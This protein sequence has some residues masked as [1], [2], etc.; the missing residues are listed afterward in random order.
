M[1]GLGR[2]TQDINPRPLPS[3]HFYLVMG[4]FNARVGTRH[5]LRPVDGA[6]VGSVVGPYNFPDTNSNGD[7]LID[8]AKSC[9]LRI[10]NTF[11]KHSEKN[12]R[13][14][15]HGRGTWQVLDHVLCRSWCL[16]NMVDSRTRPSWSGYVD[17]DH[18]V[19]T[20]TVRSNPRSK[21][22]HTMK[23]AQAKNAEVQVVSSRVGETKVLD[24]RGKVSAELHSD[25]DRLPR[26]K[27]PRC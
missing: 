10:V 19:I 6:R 12:T 17:S 22:K 16:R 7:M 9:N 3:S 23:R 4:D 11:F 14:W 26:T 15:R 2:V 8:A 18:N 24:R 25:G 1:E 27:N 5:A 13:T 20:V 21:P